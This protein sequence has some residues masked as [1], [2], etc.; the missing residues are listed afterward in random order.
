MGWIIATI[1]LS[2]L[3]V[4]IATGSIYIIVNMYNK[5][6]EFEEELETRVD[7]SLRLLDSCF[8]EIALVANKPVFFDSPEV[9]SVVSAIQRCRDAV[10]NVIEIFTDVEIED[11]TNEVTPGTAEYVSKE[12]PHN[13]KSAR[14]L[15]AETREELMKQARDGQRE[16]LNISSRNNQ[17]VQQMS[18]DP[19]AHVALT[20]HANKINRKTS[21]T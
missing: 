20:R 13:P 17:N 5:Q 14:E 12:D 10:V 4:I 3:C 7:T 16:V 2:L 8:M 15:D 9:R 21:G 6:H 18:V 1:L 19:R 11:K